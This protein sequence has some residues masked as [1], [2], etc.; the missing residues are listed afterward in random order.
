MNFAQNGLIWTTPTNSGE[1]QNRSTFIHQLSWKF[2]ISDSTFNQPSGVGKRTLTLARLIFSCALPWLPHFFP[3]LPCWK[4]PQTRVETNMFLESQWY[5]FQRLKG[6]FF[7]RKDNINIFPQLASTT[8]NRKIFFLIFSKD[9]NFLKTSKA[10]WG[11]KWF[12]TRFDV[13]WQF[14]VD[15]SSKISNM[16]TNDWGTPK[17]CF[18]QLKQ[19]S[20]FFFDHVLSSKR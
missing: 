3:L 11:F 13:H 14:V 6:R 16:W 8:T 20:L 9:T 18:A 5:L 4:T 15:W 7:S 17:S 19:K 1:N 2:M 10:L 12:N